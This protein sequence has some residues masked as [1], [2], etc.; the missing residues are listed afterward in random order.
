MKETV[1]KS[2]AI[3]YE[4]DKVIF[5]ETASKRQEDADKLMEIIDGQTRV[6]SERVKINKETCK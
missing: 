5:E 6:S 2:V 4:K 3:L 1:P